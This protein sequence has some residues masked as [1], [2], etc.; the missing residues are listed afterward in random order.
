MQEGFCIGFFLFFRQEGRGLDNKELYEK[1]YR[2]ATTVKADYAVCRDLSDHL[3]NWMKEEPEEKKVIVGHAGDVLNIESR[4]MQHY[5]KNGKYHDAENMRNLMFKTLKFSAPYNFDHFMQAMEFNRNQEDRFY[6]PRRSVLYRHARALQRLADRDIDELFL[7]QP[8]RTGKALADN[9]PVLTKEGWKKHGDLKVGD[10]V[11]G[12]DG[13]Y[14]KVLAV[15][16]KCTLDR[17]VQF[18]NGERIVCHENHEWYVCDRGFPLKKEPS[19]WE[20]KYIENRVM[21]QGV[22]GH[23][24]HRYIFQLPKKEYIQG[25][26]KELPMDP[27]TFGVWLGDGVNTNPTICGDKKDHAIIEKI[28]RNGYPVHWN[29]VHKTTGVMYYGFGF[30]PELRKMGLC[31]SNLTVPK[32]IP[33]EYLTASVQQRLELLAGLLDTDG[34]YRKSE[35]RYVFTTAEETLRDTFIDLI[36]T[37]GWRCCVVTYEPTLSSSGIQGKKKTYC[38]G[39]NP[40]CEI[41]CALERKQN[42]EFSK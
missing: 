5:S 2:S 9:T 30:R 29:T 4:I 1:M 41:P 25:E 26:E 39:F 10:S 8:P 21:E 42:H 13:K 37:F 32:Y 20:T 27:Y 14:K 18:T 11:I 24:K 16:P 36:S 17:E 3:I 15:H 40:D 6:V 19:V 12:I 23:R 28:E 31:H 38:V 22:P 35:H 7:S 33:E 34:T